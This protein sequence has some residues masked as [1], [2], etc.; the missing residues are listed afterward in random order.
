MPSAPNSDA[1]ASPLSR[2]TDLILPVAIIA[3]V[4]VIMVPLPA[5]LMDVLLAGNITVAVIVLL[6]TIYVRSPL[7][8]SV[9]PSLLLAT[10]LARLV[11][12]VATTRLIL[13]QAASAKMGAAG[14]VIMA[15]SDFVAGDKIVVGLIIF[16][17]I[18]VIQFMV[19]TKGAT[20]IS[21]VGARFALDG[22][23][24][25]Q[26]AIDADL[27]AGVINEKQAQERRLEITQQADFFGSMDGASKFV[28][29]DAIA[30]I[31]ITLINIV[32][33]LIIGVA[34]E[35]MSPFEAGELFTRL[36]IGDGLVSQVPAFLISLAAGLLVTR[37]TQRTNMPQEFLQQLFSKPQALAV[38]GGFL[39]ILIFTSLPRVPLL[40]L[41]SGC[42]GLALVLSRREKAEADKPTEEELAAK[43]P[44][45]ERVEDYLT[46]D[47]ME[48]ELGVGLIRLADP[49]RGGD[50]L[51]RVQRVRQSIASEVG[52]I[53]PKVRIRDNMRL[54]PNQYRIKIADMPIAVD[55]VEPGMMMA[56]DSGL[57]TGKID[58][59]PTKDPAF[60]ADAMWIVPGKQD[61]AEMLGYTVVEPGA[62]LATHLTE[63]C[64]RHADEILTRDAT[65]HLVDEL[66]TDSPAV[67]DELIPAVMSLAE[68]QGVLQ[69]LLQEQ[70]SIRQLALILET[71][72]DYA[73][74]SK[75]P[76]L[77]T[78]YVRHRLARQ[79]CTRYRDRDSQLHVVAFEPALE[80]KVRAG[81]E[82][83]E[84]GLFVR[85]PPQSIEKLCER[86]RE[87]VAKLT[88]EGHSPV[89]L[90][91][92]QIRAALKQISESQ[93]PQLVVLSFNEVTRDTSVVTHG[94]VTDG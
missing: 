94:M 86:I 35:G 92:P 30:G 89:V 5:S 22:M 9:F 61:Q 27:N 71:L 17:I 76:I 13:T 85:M 83:T 74:K 25:K 87:S 16:I 41:G 50:L 42:F 82:H 59:L 19:I 31:I 56:I 33:G 39:T 93:L 46:V 45:E 36:T 28:R 24:G 38:A 69:K 48:I 75:D 3:S 34:E 1:T 65:K 40:A 77:L 55:T 68:V 12:N 15:F 2:Y 43:E 66:K 67:V 79:I 60:G 32:G 23:P 90:V 58:G 53:M 78:E 80:D 47:P 70:V 11:L 88:A 72:G 52:L 10:T 37:S 73:P 26:M 84:R 6:T 62:V 57:T 14:G 81:F 4:L 51:G 63:V 8:F 64:R 21:E 54:E 18:V 49:N 91:S 44:A 29:G 7:D 20:R